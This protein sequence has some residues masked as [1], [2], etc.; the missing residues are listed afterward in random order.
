MAV[1]AELSA[2]GHVAGGWRLGVGVVM[3]EGWKDMLE[4]EEVNCLLAP[5]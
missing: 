1:T 5:S 2:V 3:R 4:G